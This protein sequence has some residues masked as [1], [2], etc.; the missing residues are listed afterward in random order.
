MLFDLADVVVHLLSLERRA[1]YDLDELW[2]RA[3]E[4]VRIQ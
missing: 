2:S 3:R 4:V 1:Y